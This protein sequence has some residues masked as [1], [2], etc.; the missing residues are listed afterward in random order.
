MLQSIMKKPN[1]CRFR[2]FSLP[3]DF[4]MKSVEGYLSSPDGGTLEVPLFETKDNLLDN[5][6]P[7]V[8]E[9][10]K[11]PEKDW[12]VAFLQKDGKDLGG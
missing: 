10:L 2:E 9:S 11:D 1:F 7:I 3:K 4:E 6:H 5:L 8:F 12:S